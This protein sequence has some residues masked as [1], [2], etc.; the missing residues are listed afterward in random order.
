MGGRRKGFPFHC[1]PSCLQEHWK[2]EGCFLSSHGK[3]ELETVTSME[4]E[5]KPAKHIG[6]P[7]G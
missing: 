5:G 3:P 7:L 1:L 4:K 2:N 6:S